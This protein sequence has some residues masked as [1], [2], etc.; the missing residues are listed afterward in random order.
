M[1]DIPRPSSGARRT[2]LN[3][4]AKPD[5]S[6]AEWTSKIKALQ[7]QVDEDEEAETRRLE[8]EIAA[9][10]KARMRRSTNLGSRASSTD[11]CEYLICIFGLP[12][13]LLRAA[14][15]SFRGAT[16]AE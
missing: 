16:V 10:R 1:T 14:T 4:P 2:T 12:C 9:S 7:R 8:A 15:F 13:F 3:I 6:L 11:L 5:A